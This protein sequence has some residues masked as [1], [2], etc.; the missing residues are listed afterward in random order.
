MSV[1]HP[2]LFLVMKRFP[3][4]EDILRR[5][6]LRNETF[7]SICEDYQKCEEALR[8]WSKSERAEAQE[9]QREYLDLLYELNSEIQQSLDEWH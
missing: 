4:R 8:Y 7:K 2:S 6:Y 1:I 5:M 3:D 9:R